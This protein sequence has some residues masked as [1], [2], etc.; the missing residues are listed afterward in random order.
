VPV[1]AVRAAGAD[2]VLY[3]GGGGGGGESLQPAAGAVG[4]SEQPA[5]APERDRQGLLRCRRPPGRD[6]C[7]LDVIAG[8]VLSREEQVF[9]AAEQGEEV[10]LGD[11]RPGS[12]GGRRC[13]VEA[14]PGELVDR[15]LQHLRAPLI[16]CA[17][18]PCAGRSGRGPAGGVE[19]WRGDRLP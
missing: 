3:L 4:V 11:V 5:A 19:R 12:D 9:L 10:W 18:A 2:M 15:R 8:T 16:R 6:E 14:M 17:P 7:G 1:K 13:L